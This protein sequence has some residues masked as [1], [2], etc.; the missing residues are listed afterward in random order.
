[1]IVEIENAAPESI[2]CEV[3]AVPFS[4]SPSAVFRRLDERLRGRLAG[5]VA[6]G[7]AKGEAGKTVLLHVSPGEEV[8]AARVVIVGVGP[9]DGLDE[10]SVRTA[11]AAG[12]RAGKSFGGSV[13]W[14]RSTSMVSSRANG[15]FPVSSSNR[16]TPTL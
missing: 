5:L 2:P 16:I 8:A 3:L 15:S 11:A 4:E 7:E 1:M 12:A 6:S 14:A 13:A 10:D 9:G